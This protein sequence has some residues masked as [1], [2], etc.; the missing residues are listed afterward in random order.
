MK[1]RW[2]PSPTLRLSLAAH[3]AAGLGALAAPSL[4]PLALGAVAANQALLIGA[5]MLPRNSLLGPNVTRLPA[6]AAAR[7]EIA[8]T[9]D[10]GPFP[11]ITPRVLDLLDAAG[12]RASF[13]CIG[14]KAR[15][16]PALTREI[17]T[18]GHAV[19]NHSM[20]HLYHFA[21]LGYA[22][23]RREVADGQACLADITGRAP[24]FF[25]PTA[26]LRN[27]F[28]DPILAA[29]G[30]HLAT[31]TRRGFDTRTGDPSRV[32]AR[33]A[34]P[35]AGGDILLLHDDNAALTPAGIP[36]ILDVL[37]RLLAVARERRLATVT[38]ASVIPP[39]S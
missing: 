29:L 30:L 1:H 36:V 18:R 28:L 27:P 10:D 26:G 2:R 4:W 34:G 17:V 35:L 38:L 13:F 15:Q 22:R 12:A 16:H 23:M 6:Q 32:L 8:L 14:E 39:R 25:R 3:V 24:A 33:L 9:I 21:A 5:G 20:H 19:E 11:E 37:P 31:W 7:G